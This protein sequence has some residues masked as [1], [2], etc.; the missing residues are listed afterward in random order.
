MGD[1]DWRDKDE[2]G[3]EWMAKDTRYGVKEA[4]DVAMNVEKEG[5]GIGTIG[6]DVIVIQ[7]IMTTY[8]S[9]YHLG[10]KGEYL[11]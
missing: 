8:I 5:W 6:L 11:L 9:T 7:C 10:T 4:R 3:N 2:G 1:T